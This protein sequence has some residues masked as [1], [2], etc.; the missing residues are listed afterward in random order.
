MRI[1]FDLY[2]FLTSYLFSLYENAN[3]HNSK[4]V[5]AY[6]FLSKNKISA[7]NFKKIE[8]VKSV[9]GLAFFYRFLRYFFPDWPFSA[10]DL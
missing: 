7:E 4:E 1:A 3:I 9:T 10:I 5:A 8:S 6:L 2:Y